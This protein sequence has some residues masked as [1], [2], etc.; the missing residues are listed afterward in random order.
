MNELFKKLVE[1]EIL[2]DETRVQLEEA[3]AQQLTEAVEAAKKEA[4]ETVTAEIHENWMKERDLLIEALDGK[5]TELVESELE[6]LRSDI[7]SFRDVEAESAA[8]L[9]EAKAQMADALKGDMKQL[10]E[11][12]DG[13]LEAR[14]TTELD[15]LREDVAVVKKNA[16]GQRMYE[17]FVAEFKASHVEEGSTEAKLTETEQQLSEAQAAL[18]AAQERAEAA[19][20]SIKL[21]QVL[22]PLSGRT[23]EV[24]E[25]IL[26]RVATPKLDEAY[27]TYVSRVLHE[28]SS[29]KEVASEKETQVLAEGE[30]KEIVSGV[31]KS[32]DNK[33]TIAEAKVISEAEAQPTRNL[34]AE[35]RKRIQ[36]LGGILG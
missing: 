13:F 12:L 24:M 33:E 19:E 4:T 1:S 16:F 36:R 23:K 18:A 29:Q 14:L 31:V 8:A 32:G 7:E 28:T 35:D 6:E 15:E 26:A 3:L 17:A 10:I 2:T 27:N 5:V 22:A 25:A 9:V 21:A 34:S 20:R 30:K 11:K